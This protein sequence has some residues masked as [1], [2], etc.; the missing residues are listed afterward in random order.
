M[1]PSRKILIIMMAVLVSGVFTLVEK[2][3]TIANITFEMRQML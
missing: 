3:D 1:K 2:A